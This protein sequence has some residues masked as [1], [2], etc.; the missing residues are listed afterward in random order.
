[1]IWFKLLASSVVTLVSIGVLI[2]IFWPSA[3]SSA[4]VPKPAVMLLGSVAVV[5]LAA[6]PVS[7]MGLIWV[8]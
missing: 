7:L 8:Y 5:C 4:D 6:I 3:R 1:M 2:Q